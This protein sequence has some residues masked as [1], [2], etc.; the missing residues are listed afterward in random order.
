MSVSGKVELVHKQADVGA[1]CLADFDPYQF[2][3]CHE[4]HSMKLEGRSTILSLAP[5]R[6]ISD[7]GL[8]TLC[9]PQGLYDDQKS[10]VSIQAGIGGNHRRIGEAR[11]SRRDCIAQYDARAGKFALDPAIFD[12]DQ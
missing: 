3:G 5:V 1:D 7:T 8:I 6:P 4:F 10:S 11:R 12:L 2:F 9:R